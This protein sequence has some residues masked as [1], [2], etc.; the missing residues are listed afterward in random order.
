MINSFFNEKIISVSCLVLAVNTIN[1]LVEFD[2]YRPFFKE[3]KIKEIFKK[4]NLIEQLEGRL[5]MSNFPYNQ[6]KL[7]EELLFKLNN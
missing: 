5:F 3:A 1:K 7:V 6:M 4:N 2:E